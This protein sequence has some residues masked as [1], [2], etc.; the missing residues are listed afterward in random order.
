MPRVPVRLERDPILEAIFE[1]RFRGSVAAA[2]EVLQGAIFPK[3]KDRF[4]QVQRTAFS[5]FA[6]FL[7][8]PNLQYQPRLI[9]LGDN[10]RVHIGD[11]AIGLVCVKPYVGWKAFRPLILELLQIVIASKV[12][13]ESER[14][15]LKYTNLLEGKTTYAEQFSLV[16][17]NASLGRAKY[18]LSECLTFT[19]S[20]IQ[21]D[22]LINIV[23]LGANSEIQ[24][25][26]GSVKGL[27]IAVDSIYN[28][29]PDFLADP[30][31]H[32]EKV[33]DVEKSVF[34]GVLTDNTIESMGPKWG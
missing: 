11:R 13:N 21:K 32:V 19:R 9:L 22:G 28:S 34:F 23:E 12:V 29:P 20:E 17:Y 7:D 18:N 15:S 25:P 1:F 16:H 31:P 10:L 5:Q 4:P 33:H 2:A 8:D 14:I 24:A 30:E 6:G 3:L 26:T 27:Y